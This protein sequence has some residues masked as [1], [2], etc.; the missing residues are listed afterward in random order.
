M[1]YALDEN[2]KAM[3]E[4]GIASA[5]RAFTEA[6]AVEIVPQRLIAQAGF[7]LL[8]T[9]AMGG[10]PASSVV[11]SNCRAHS[12]PNVMI[13]DGSVFTT[14]AALNPTPTIQALA[15]RAADMLGAPAPRHGDCG[16]SLA[17]SSTR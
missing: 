10:D 12:V 7:H 14:A 16:M 2:T 4:H 3:I 1:T 9:A 13:V 6:G 17:I 11:D 5:T 15:L 8:G